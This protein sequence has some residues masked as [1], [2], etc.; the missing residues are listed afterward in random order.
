MTEIKKVGL[1]CQMNTKQLGSIY[2]K[3]LR[4]RLI[5]QGLVQFA[6]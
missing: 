6:V 4:N 3:N 2:T 1:A 5:Y